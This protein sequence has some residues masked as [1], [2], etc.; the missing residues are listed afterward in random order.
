M[1]TFYFLK[2]VITTFKQP[3]TTPPKKIMFA[4]SSEKI[5]LKNKPIKIETTLKI[6]II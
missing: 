6:P 5:S 2:K 4:T 1:R 3:M